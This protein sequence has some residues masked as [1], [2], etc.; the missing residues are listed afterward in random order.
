MRLAGTADFPALYTLWQ[1][2]FGDSPAAVKGFYEAFPNCRTYVLEQ[3]G[4][5]AAMAH[6]LPRTL[7]LEEDV[8]AGYLYAVATAK[9]LR[10]QGLGKRLLAG[11]EQDA[12]DVGFVCLLTV[13]A[14]A[15]LISYYEKLGYVPA[16]GRKHS[17]FPGGREIA[18]ADYLARRDRLLSLP[19]TVCDEAT[20]SYAQGVYG[21]RCYE[22]EK[23]IALHGGDRTEEV[24]PEDTGGEANGLIRWLTQPKTMP[25]GYLGFALD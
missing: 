21:L 12:K 10:N 2:A 4:R 24:L 7:R 3:D 9:D 11:V 6:V 5:L 15:G 25:L 13:P 20:L 23:G 8:S 16:F 19:H 18:P 22:T 17:P 14:E 1:E